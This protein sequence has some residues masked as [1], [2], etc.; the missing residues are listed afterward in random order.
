MRISCRACYVVTKL[1]NN[2]LKKK[3]NGAAITMCMSTVVNLAHPTRELG[4]ASVTHGMI[5]PF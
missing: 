4:G 5:I 3:Q 1:H 2:A